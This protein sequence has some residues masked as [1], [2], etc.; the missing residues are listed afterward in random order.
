MKKIVEKHTKLEDTYLFDFIKFDVGF[1]ES[2]PIMMAAAFLFTKATELF[3]LCVEKR[4]NG[5][6]KIPH[7]EKIKV[8]QNKIRGQLEKAGQLQ[9]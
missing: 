4:T 5:K 3:R 2:L 9:E 1:Q 7:D 8:R 6:E